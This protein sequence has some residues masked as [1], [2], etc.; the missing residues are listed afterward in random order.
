MIIY[1][2]DIES[3]NTQVGKGEFYIVLR[4]QWK[5]PIQIILNL[6]HHTLRSPSIIKKKL[7]KLLWTWEA[8]VFRHKSRYSLLVRLIYDKLFF[9]SYEFLYD[10]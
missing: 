2:I 10:I 8:N 7:V 9:M 6:V 4:N 5:Q 3:F 1:M